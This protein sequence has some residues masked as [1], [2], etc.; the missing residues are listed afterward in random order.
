M[1]SVLHF[2]VA[3]G[4]LAVILQAPLAT[5]QIVT[6]ALKTPAVPSNLE[7]PKGNMLFLAGHAQGTQNYICLP[8]AG[9]FAWTFFSPTATLFQD[10]Q[11]GP[12]DIHQQ[13]ITHFLSPNPEEKGTSRVTWQSSIDSS[14]V[15]AKLATNGSST[16]RNFVAE[17]AI[18][19]LLLEEVGT[20]RAPNNGEILSH[21]TYVQRLNTGGGVA[22]SAGCSEASNVGATALVPYSADYYFYK[23]IPPQ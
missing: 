6:P 18:P 20:F 4:T 7:V 12:I 9:T 23:A 8:S 3:A 13:I 21:T 19:W 1:K 16:D 14:A 11:L 17:G 5:A 15:W 22:P 2:F 10:F